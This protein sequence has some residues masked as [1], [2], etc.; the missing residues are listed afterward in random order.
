MHRVTT[1]VRCSPTQSSKFKKEMRNMSTTSHLTANQGAESYIRTELQSLQCRCKRAETKLP[2][3]RCSS[4]RASH[5]RRGSCPSSSPPARS[6]ST[7]QTLPS[8]PHI[9]Q[10]CRASRKDALRGAGQ[11]HQRQERQRR[12]AHAASCYCAAAAPPEGGPGGEGAGRLPRRRCRLRRAVSRLLRLSGASTR[13]QGRASRPGP[14]RHHRCLKGRARGSETGLESQC[15]DVNA[16]RCLGHS[17]SL[18]RLSVV[19]PA[20]RT[21]YL[22]SL[23]RA[24][25]ALA[26]AQ[27]PGRILGAAGRPWGR[28]S[29]PLAQLPARAARPPAAVRCWPPMQGQL[30]LC[31]QVA[32]LPATLVELA[33]AS[34]QWISQQSRCLSP[35]CACTHDVARRSMLRRC[36][37]VAAPG[38]K[39]GT[40]FAPS[41]VTAQ[42]GMHAVRQEDA[43]RDGSCWGCRALPSGRVGAG[44]SCQPL[45]RTRAW[46]PNRRCRDAYILERRQHGSQEQGCHSP[47]DALSLLL[48]ALW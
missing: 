27:L 31:K 43:V 46:H 36:Q 10:T 29:K 7:P 1:T 35:A 42:G 12:P 5:N 16:A 37:T 48:V 28:S 38:S 15:Q 39:L 47:H 40:R 22:S 8:P 32:V 19:I 24:A 26:L 9:S 44:T 13:L 2:V 41:Q 30:L 20:C 3:L 17:A 6:H 25:G 14:P 11:Q 18:S 4:S 34:L 33:D 21:R 23:P 45:C